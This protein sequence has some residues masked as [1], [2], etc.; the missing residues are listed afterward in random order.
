MTGGQ[1]FDRAA[2]K[3]MLDPIPSGVDVVYSNRSYVKD[4]VGARTETADAAPNTHPG[5][6]VVKNQASPRRSSK[7]RTWL[8]AYSFRRSED[9]R[10]FALRCERR[11]VTFAS[12]VALAA[13][14]G[15][16]S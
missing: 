5:R 1:I 15:Y 14:V 7:T 13:T 6:T 10:R 3:A 16:C 9:F 8:S 4:E 12:A 2:A 11:V